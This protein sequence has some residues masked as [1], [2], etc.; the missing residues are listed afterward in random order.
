MTNEKSNSSVPQKPAE[1]KAA[2]QV[3][4]G[5]RH[6]KDFSI[7]PSEFCQRNKLK[8]LESNAIKYICRSTTGAKDNIKDLR[9]ARHCI[10]L[11]L[12]WEYGYVESENTAR[13][14]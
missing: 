6:Y 14:K 8:H 13:P 3:Q 5:G 10:D 11:I 7:Q 12:E 1:K 4:V 9:K 2:S